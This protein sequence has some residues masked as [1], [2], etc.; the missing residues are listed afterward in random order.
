[1]QCEEVD[2][3]ILEYVNGELQGLELAQ[4]EEHL[5]ICEACRNEAE[6]S[7]MLWVAMEK[8]PTGKPAPNARARFDRMLESYKQ[9]LE[10]ARLEKAKAEAA[11]LGFYEQKV[12]IAMLTLGPEPDSNAIHDKLCKMTGKHVSLNTLFT[13]IDRLEERGLLQSRQS[14]INK[15]NRER[16]KRLYC[17]EAAGLRALEETLESAKQLKQI[18]EENSG[19]AQTWISNFAKKR[20]QDS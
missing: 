7:K 16:P 18:L 13:A 2:E 11:P 10:Q 5:R 12:L 19:R 14:E 15:P 6:S 8:I 4:F 9:E 3:K 17:M 20:L 1:M